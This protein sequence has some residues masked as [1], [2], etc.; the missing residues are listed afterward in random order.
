MTSSHSELLQLKNLGMASVNI[1][2]AIGINTQADLKRTGAVEAYRRIKARDINVSKVMLYALQGA[3]MD[4]HWN[5]LA[6]DLKR[7]LVEDAEGKG[8]TSQLGRVSA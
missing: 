8:D 6:P 4:V 1:L 2:R 7:K 3:L 5:D